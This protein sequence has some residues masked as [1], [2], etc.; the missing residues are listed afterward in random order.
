[1]QHRDK[2]V[3]L[4]VFDLLLCR[5]KTGLQ[6]ALTCVWSSKPHCNDL[7]E[8]PFVFKLAAIN[9]KGMV[10]TSI[11]EQNLNIILCTV[12]SNRYLLCF[13]FNWHPP[14]PVFVFFY[15]LQ[16]RKRDTI[17]YPHPQKVFSHFKNASKNCISLIVWGFILPNFITA[18]YVSFYYQ[19][20]GVQSKIMYSSKMWDHP[21][22]N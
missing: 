17:V 3:V 7:A 15:L 4:M 2:G 13:C 8:P 1:M 21:M 10:H 9:L 20:H 6:I 18:V 22:K 12:C 14:L 11:S 16:S 5:G 19:P